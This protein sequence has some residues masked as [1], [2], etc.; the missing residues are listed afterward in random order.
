MQTVHGHFNGKTVE[1]D[2]TP[3]IETETHVLITFLE[4]SL[5]T[6]AAR[7][8]RLGHFGDPLLRPPHVYGDELRRQMASQYRRFTVGA[9]M[10]RDI[11][12]VKPS[13]KVAVALHM[14][15]QKGVTSVLAEPTTDADGWGIMTMRDILKHIVVDRRSPEEITVG[16]ICTHNLIRAE[17]DTS[18]RECAEMMINSRVRRVVIY[19]DNAP[20][21]IISDTDIF[22]FVEERGWGPAH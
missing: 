19:Q 22:Q 11:L 2:E 10:S 21:G 8:Q 9:L 5:E 13:A 12:T 7:E 3:P 6:A 17:P 20:V 1:L 18:L 15:R 16:E 14:M 4:G